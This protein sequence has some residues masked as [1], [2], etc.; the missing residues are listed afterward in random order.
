L[1]V[2]RGRDRALGY[3]G[4]RLTG[5]TKKLGVNEERLKGIRGKTLV[6]LR[7]IKED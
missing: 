1:G 4:S 2:L 6:A 3:R 5:V 7:T